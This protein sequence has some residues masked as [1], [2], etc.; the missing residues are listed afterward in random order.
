M[1]PP[2]FERLRPFEPMRYL[3]LVYV[4]MFLLMGG[5]IGKHVLKRQAWRWVLLFAPLCAG[6]SYAQIDMYPATAHFEWPGSV[7]GNRWVRAFAWVS[8]N[9][10]VQ[11]YFALNPRYMA[12]PGEDYH[13]FRALAGRSALA[14]NLKDPGMAARVPRLANRWLAESTALE[15]WKSFGADD[16]R[17]LKTE[18]GVDWAVVENPSVGGLDCPYRDGDLRICRLN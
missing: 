7:S 16:F 13:G 14:D 3:Q 18:F 12:L 17:R 11:S 9:T 2:G 10:P 15:G 8:A 4:L 6:M 1:L 5:L